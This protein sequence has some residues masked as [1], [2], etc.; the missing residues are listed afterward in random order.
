M[1]SAEEE[2]NDA[3]DPTWA[4][5]WSWLCEGLERRGIWLWSLLNE[6]VREDKG[7]LGPCIG[8]I[9][10]TRHIVKSN[11]YSK[12]LRYLP[13]NNGTSITEV[14]QCKRRVA[15]PAPSPNMLRPT[16]SPMTFFHRKRL[17]N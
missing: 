12:Q 6:R 10:I 16:S 11:Q 4:L 15:Q 17:A 8:V 1:W 2:D 3:V 14:T 9:N 13:S 7:T 5:K